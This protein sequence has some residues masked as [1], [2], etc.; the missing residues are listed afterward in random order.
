[1]LY[2]FTRN[3]TLLRENFYNNQHFPT[4]IIEEK[5]QKLPNIYDEKSRTL[6][7]FHYPTD[8]QFLW[9]FF[10]LWLIHIIFPNFSTDLWPLIDFRTCL[11][12]ISCETIGGFDQIWYLHWYFLCL[13][14]PQTRRCVW[15]WRI[16]DTIRFVE[17]LLLELCSL[18]YQIICPGS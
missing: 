5:T 1:M 4:I 10:M 17:E 14:I 7:R 9:L 2:K 12:S 8:W 3:V 15:F 11:C 18:Y 6:K 13:L 16:A